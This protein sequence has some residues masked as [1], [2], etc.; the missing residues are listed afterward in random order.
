MLI[1]P[2]LKP[3][4]RLSVLGLMTVVKGKVNVP[5]ALKRMICGVY[6]T[7][8]LIDCIVSIALVIGY[9]MIA[10]EL[11]LLTIPKGIKHI[12]ANQSDKLI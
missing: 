6:A 2:R 11:V 1:A 4:N 3:F 10:I 12:F 5:T 9:D 8:H 7:T